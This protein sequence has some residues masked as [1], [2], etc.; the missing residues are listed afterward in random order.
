LLSL[1]KPIWSFCIFNPSS[2]KYPS[3]AELEQKTFVGWS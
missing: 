2:I 1:R 3:N